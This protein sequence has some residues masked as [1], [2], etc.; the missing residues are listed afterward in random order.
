MTRNAPTCINDDAAWHFGERQIDITVR[1][2][3]AVSTM[4]RLKAL[5][6]PVHRSIVVQ[7]RHVQ[8]RMHHDSGLDTWL[9]YIALINCSRWR[10]NSVAAQYNVLMLRSFQS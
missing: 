1:P 8:L 5:S 7:L 4:I 9:I 6:T 3:R 10:R 2:W